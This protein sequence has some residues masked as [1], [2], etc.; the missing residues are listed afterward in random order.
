MVL[1]AENLL[2]NNDNNITLLIHIFTNQTLA[3]LE[4]NPTAQNLAEN[5]TLIAQAFNNKTSITLNSITYDF[6]NT[7][8]TI[9]YLQCGHTHYDANLVYNDIPIIITRNTTQSAPYSFDL[10]YVDYDESKLHLIR[11]GNGSDR[12]IDIL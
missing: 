6:S 8:G 7:T 3:D 11:I 12:V 9:N 1:I 2:N 10:C 5:I 4:S